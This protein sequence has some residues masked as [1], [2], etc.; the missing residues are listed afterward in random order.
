MNPDQRSVSAAFVVVLGILFIEHQW[1]QRFI[2]WLQGVGTPG[3]TT[4]APGAQTVGTAQAGAA[5][6]L[7][8]GAIPSGTPSSGVSGTIPAVP[9]GGSGT[10][11]SWI[12]PVPAGS[13]PITQGFGPADASVAGLEPGGIHQGIDFGVPSGTSVLA[14]AQGQVVQAG[15]NGGYGNSITLDLGNGI[16][17]LYGHLSSISVQMGQ[18]V[19]Q[20]DV[21][22]LS[23][24][25]GVSTGPH[26]HFGVMQGGQWVDPLGFLKGLL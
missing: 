17:V 16:R 15:P 6:P 14:V 26:L 20:G 8:G 2:A 22:G 10:L 12:L 3:S 18:I 21:L 11:T 5:A 19:G 7:L 4:Q 25:T 13:G 24:S 1:L 23:G 9:A